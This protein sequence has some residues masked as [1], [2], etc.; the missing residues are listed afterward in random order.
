MIN[1]L[2]MFSFDDFSNK[3]ISRHGWY[4]REGERVKALVGND[5]IIGNGE[6]YPGILN[7]GRI[8][9]GAGNDRIISA[10][11][12]VGAALYNDGVISTGA[13]RDIID[14]IIGGFEG[15][16]KILLGD[17]NDT[18]KGFGYLTRAYGGTGTDKVLLASNDTGRKNTNKNIDEYLIRG[19][20]IIG[21]N[22]FSEWAMLAKGFEQIGGVNGGLFDFKDGTI[23]VDTNGIATFT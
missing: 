23:T 19:N 6:Q 9:T 4:V 1:D 11:R 22:P 16:G 14:V 18:L 15:K 5:T 21:L 10:A 17:D 8:D 13:G 12:L 20:R 3:A 7:Y 2:A